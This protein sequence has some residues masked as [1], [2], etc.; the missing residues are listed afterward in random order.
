MLGTDQYGAAHYGS[1]WYLANAPQLLSPTG[2]LA[3]STWLASSGGDLYT[4]VDE[5]SPDEADYTYTATPGAWEEFTFP[6]PDAAHNG[7]ASGGYVRYRI[8]AGSGEITVDLKQGAAVLETWGPH[9]LTGALQAFEQ[10]I[11]ATTSDSS[12]LRVR[13]TAS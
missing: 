2:Q 13:F 12:D 8:P 10:P 5:T 7:D 6:S 4:C 1:L 9:T 11:T 3:G